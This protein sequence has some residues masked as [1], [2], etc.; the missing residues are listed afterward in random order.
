ME[1]GPT[2]IKKRSVLSESE[3]NWVLA[4][5]QVKDRILIDKAFHALV[6]WIKNYIQTNVETIRGC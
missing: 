6:F 5:P 3:T 4:Q 1:A 2:L